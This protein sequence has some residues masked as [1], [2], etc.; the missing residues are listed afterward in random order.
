MVRKL[1][2]EPLRSQ[3][4]GH[5]SEIASD[6]DRMHLRW[7]TLTDPGGRVAGAVAPASFPALVI[8]GLG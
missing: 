3:G 2:R 7:G 4:H 6:V 8:G 1:V 5:A